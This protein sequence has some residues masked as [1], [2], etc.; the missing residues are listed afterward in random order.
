MNLLR[1]A[2]VA[3][4][5]TTFALWSAPLAA[6]SGQRRRAPDEQGRRA[7]QGQTAQPRSPQQHGNGNRQGQDEH[8]A[9]P[10]E[11]A[12]PAAAAPAQRAEPEHRAEP[13]GANR[14]RAEPQ[15]GEQRRAEPQRSPQ[16]RTEPQRRAVPRGRV[17]APPRAR[18]YA[19]PRTYGYSRPRVRIPVIVYPR[20]YYAFRPHLW[21]GHGLYIG[22]G[23][24]Y[25]LNYGP[26]TYIYPE[27]YPP[28]GIIAQGAYGGMSFDVTPADAD[29]SVDGVYVGVAADFSSTHQPLTV[30][31]G[32]HH[33]ELQAPDAAPVAFDVDVAPGQVVPFQGSLTY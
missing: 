25:P 26:P 5:V 17:A 15:R 23:V 30:T 4:I 9:Q 8:R 24:P 16:Q 27:V 19:E 29:V 28:G 20:R 12:P 32:R 21:I 31:P 14:Q 2:A 6:Q 18:A 33:V 11:T 13:Q 22:V 3:A 10:R 1:A 7:P